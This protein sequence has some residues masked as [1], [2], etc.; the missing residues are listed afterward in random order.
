MCIEEL[1][2]VG[3]LLETVVLALVGRNKAFEIEQGSTS[4]GMDSAAKSKTEAMQRAVSITPPTPNFAR[5][6]K[7]LPFGILWPRRA[8]GRDR[9]GQ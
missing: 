2:S 1:L 9:S 4:R 7:K 6:M 3:S 5:F 8:Y